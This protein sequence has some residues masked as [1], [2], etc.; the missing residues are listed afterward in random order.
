[1]KT[2]KIIWETIIVIFLTLFTDE[3]VSNLQLMVGTENIIVFG[4]WF[5]IYALYAPPWGIP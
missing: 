2:Q 4:R 3:V 5:F 1:M